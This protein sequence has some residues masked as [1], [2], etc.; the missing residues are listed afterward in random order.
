MSEIEEGMRVQFTPKNGG[1]FPTGERSRLG[2]V[3]AITD[4]ELVIRQL[5]DD[6]TKRITER[7]IVGRL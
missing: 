5:E 3:E 6:Y 7:Q 2:E 1:E 4:D